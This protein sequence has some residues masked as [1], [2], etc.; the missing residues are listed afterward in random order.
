MWARADRTLS[1]LTHST[2]EVRGA[3][4]MTNRPIYFQFHSQ[5]PEASRDFF[6]EV[7]DWLIDD[8]PGMEDYFQANTGADDVPGI[9]GGLFKSMDGASRTTITVDVDNIDAHISHAITNGGVLVMPKTPIPGIGHVAYCVEPGG[10][11]FGLVQRDESVV[12][13]DA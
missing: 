1:R 11:L 13:P 12:T 9:H 7:F 6:E 5:N 10:I 2:I 4:A 8:L 3:N